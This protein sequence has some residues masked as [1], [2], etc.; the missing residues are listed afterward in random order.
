MSQPPSHAASPFQFTL[1]QLV[2]LIAGMRRRLA[3]I[4]LTH[5][6]LLLATVLVLPGFA[7]DRAKGG[8]GTL[9]AMLAGIFMFVARFSG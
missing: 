1:G 2:A 8:S 9:G 6:S 3:V 4:R 7:Y 5:W